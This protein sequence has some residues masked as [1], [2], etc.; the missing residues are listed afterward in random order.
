M[1]TWSQQHYLFR[2]AN[3]L[4]K[5]NESVQTPQCALHSQPTKAYC[6]IVLPTLD[7]ML[8]CICSVVHVGL[9]TH[10]GVIRHSGHFSTGR[11]KPPHPHS[12]P[13]DS[14]TIAGVNTVRALGAFCF[15][16]STSLTGYYFAARL[17]LSSQV[18]NY[19]A[20]V[21]Y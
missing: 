1:Y 14:V 15:I 2:D 17:V 10:S 9:Q 6:Q 3:C 13:S 4:R 16:S 19:L 18:S 8:N 11:V 20:F 7:Q 12:M 5:A 21:C